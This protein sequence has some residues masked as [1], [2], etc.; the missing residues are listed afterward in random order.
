MALVVV[1]VLLGCAC[2]GPQRIRPGIAKREWR[3]LR[4]RHF[5]LT[6]DLPKEKAIARVR[7][8]EELWYALAALYVI[9]APEQEPPR[10]T[11][12]VVHLRSRGEFEA[13]IWLPKIRGF[14]SD[15]VDF[16]EAP[17]VVTCEAFEGRTE[18]LLHE[19]AHNFNHI[20]FPH[21]PVWL[22]EGLAT[23]YQTVTVEKGEAVVG[24]PS[25]TD[26][27]FYWGHSW[28]T[29]S[30]AKLLSM[31]SDTF[32]EG[33]RLNYFAAWKLVHLLSSGSEDYHWRFRRY[34]SLL[35]QGATGAAAWADAFHGLPFEK[36]S[37]AYAK[38]Q[39]RHR[40]RLWRIPIRDR[41]PSSRVAVRRLRAGEVHALWAELQMVRI[42]ASK[43]K[44]PSL[45]AV[46]KHLDFAARSDPDWDGVDF[47]RAAFVFYFSKR[48]DGHTDP[49]AL[50]DRYLEREPLD[51]RARLG[52][53]RVGLRAV[54]PEDYAGFGPEPPG[55]AGLEERVRALVRVSQSVEELHQVAWYFALRKNFITGLGFAR[56]ALAQDPGCARCVD[57]LALLLYHAGR[58]AE[59]LAAQERAINML[60]EEEPSEG[61]RK[62]LERYRKAAQASP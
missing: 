40:L 34:L 1:A 7:E 32:Y 29:P 20:Y 43:K 61:M 18:I 17:L 9:V 35:G 25:I 47:W 22:N 4:S 16:E 19:L 3:E 23:F 24:R 13:L 30:L 62:R 42:R 26:R 56:R 10:M 48:G 33:G 50:L 21:S 2:G 55:L 28:I 39:R 37:S 52:A 53:V 11:I 15:T 14:V 12:Q 46:R 44:H 31:D 60:D 45:E 8:L 51:S 54:V 57:T 58:P 6:T 38:H 36:I 49:G 5:R 41:A 27:W 59:A